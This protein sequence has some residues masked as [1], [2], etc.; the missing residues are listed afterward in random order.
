MPRFFLFFLLLI[1]Y[2]AVN[3]SFKTNLFVHRSTLP[4]KKSLM[5]QFREKRAR[6]QVPQV[7]R[8][9]FRACSSEL[10]A[11]SYFQFMRQLRFERD[12]EFNLP[13]I[14]HP[15]IAGWNHSF[16]VSLEKELKRLLDRARHLKDD[17]VSLF[18]H[19]YSSVMHFMWSS[20]REIMDVFYVFFQLK[21]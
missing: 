10:Y 13:Q 16:H 4:F 8:S 5:L 6:L 12:Q 7:D 20:F 14:S 19:L 3:T 17:E 2:F 21:D 1:L 15:V 18:L 9:L 11:S